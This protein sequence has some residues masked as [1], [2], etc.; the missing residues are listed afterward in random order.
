MHLTLRPAAA[1]RVA[2]T[3]QATGAVALVGLFC[4]IVMYAGVPVFGPLNDGCIALA[5]LLS[6]A[7]AWQLWR[8]R[9]R[10]APRLGPL[11]LGAA[12]VGALVVASGSAFV[13]LNVTG[14]VLAGF[15][16]AV[17]NA[18]IGLWLLAVCAPASGGWPRG[19]TRLGRVAGA[20][21]A[22]GLFCLPALLRGLDTLAV[23]P[24]Y[25]NVSYVSWLGTFILF[26]L[27]CL[28]L[29][30]VETVS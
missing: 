13:L 11:A 28:W 22:L 24:W 17:G 19:L 30:R 6:G 2:G 12:G 16:M 8:A 9:T 21:M 3:A 1:G 26:P 18:G 4:L 15:Y 5:G 29:G 23:S 14:F 27:W 10:P 7:L 20:L 25:V